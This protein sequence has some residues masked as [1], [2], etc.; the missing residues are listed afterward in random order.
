MRRGAPQAAAAQRAQLVA[1]V[2]RRAALRWKRI[3]GG[4][5]RP[6]HRVKV[7]DLV[8]GKVFRTGARRTQHVP[9]R[10]ALVEAGD[11]HRQLRAVCLDAANECDHRT[12]STTTETDDDRGWSLLTHALHERLGVV[13]ELEYERRVCFANS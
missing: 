2:E 13:T 10:G 4:C 11:H 7:V 12:A 5:K 1:A 6:Q 8:E 9:S 3:P